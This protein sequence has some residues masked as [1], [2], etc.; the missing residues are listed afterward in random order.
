MDTLIQFL[1]TCEHQKVNVKLKF[2]FDDKYYEY[3]YLSTIRN[4]K[5][6][7]YDKD[8]DDEDI[9]LIKDIEEYRPALNNRL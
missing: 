4:D 3:P 2:Y 5:I 8:W 7:F 6:I 9:V 1:N